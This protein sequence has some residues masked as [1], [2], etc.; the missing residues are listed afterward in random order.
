MSLLQGEPG[1]ATPGEPGKPGFPG[2]RGNPGES[3]EIGLPGPPGLPGTPGKEGPDGPPGT[4][5]NV[6]TFLLASSTIG[7]LGALSASISANR[8]VKKPSPFSIQCGCSVFLPSFFP[9]S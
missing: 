1:L 5:P 3:G 8:S 2:E 4:R 9:F 6:I 7:A